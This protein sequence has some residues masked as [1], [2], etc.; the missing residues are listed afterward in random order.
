MGLLNIYNTIDH[1]HETLVA[2][3][4]LKDILPDVDFNHALVIKAGNRLNGEYIVSEDDVLYIRKVPGS[5]AV[6][7]VI[8]IVCAVVAVG[9]GVGSAIYAQKASKKAEEQME[10]AQRDAQNLSQ[11]IQQLPFIR[12]AKN[13]RALGE[14]VQFLMGS[15]YN[16]P[17]NLTDGFYSIGGNDGVDSYYSAAFSCGFNPQKITKILIGNEAICT[18][19]DGIDGVLSFDSS[20]I[21]FK[22]NENRVEVCQPGRPLSLIN[23]MQKVNATYAGAELKHDYGEAAVPVIV[24]AANNAMQIQVCI[25]FS[26]LRKYD[27][28]SGNWITNRAQ[29]SPYWS[30]NGGKTWHLFYFA[31]AET[32]TIK[33]GKETI[34]HDNVF[35]RNVN[36]NIR[37]V[38]TKTFTAEESYGKQISIKVVKETPKEK[39]N[40]QEDCA[41][42]WYQT[43]CYD[44]QKSTSSRLEMCLIEEA[45]LLNKTTRV[46]YRIIADS[47][48]QNLLDELHCVTEAE[49]RTW[50]GSAWSNTK[51]ATRNPASW[52]LEV[53]TSD[54]HKPSQMQDSELDLASFGALYEYCAENNFYCDG[55]I[56]RSEKK[57]DVIERILK[58]C[59]ASLIINNEGLYEVCI[60]K[61]EENPV[62]LL[63][64]ENIVSFSFSK[65]LAKK[66]DGSKVTFTNRDSWTVDTFYSMLNGG[67]YDYR[68]DTVDTL[69]IE[70]ATTYEHAY[71]I[72][73]RQLRQRQLQPREI[74][75][76]V[77][78]EGDYYPLYSTVLLQLPHLLQGL[79]SSVI[80]AIRF[81]ANLEITEIEI[82]DLVDFVQ[83]KRYGVIIQATND[84]GHK[85][86][87]GE[88]INATATSSTRILTF[89]APLAT[90]GQIIPERG[91]H[92]SFGLLD[93]NGRFSKITNVMKI[94]GIEPNGKDG[95]TLTLR[96]YSKEVYA[97]TP[98]GVPIPAYHS[99][100]TIPQQKEKTVSLDDLNELR[101]QMN[102]SIDSVLINPEDGTNPPDVTGL[103]ASASKDGITIK[104]DSVTSKGLVNSAKKYHIEL[105]K[106]N[107]DTWQVL[108]VS[109]NNQSF[110]SFVRTGDGADGY[111]EASLFND[112]LFRVKAE[113]IYGAI[114][115][116]W[117]VTDNIDVSDYGTWIPAIPTLIK[118][119]AEEGGI[120]FKWNTPAGAND[121]KLYGANTYEIN[122]YY[123]N[124]LR[125]T[126]NIDNLEAV[127]NFDRSVDGYPEKPSVIN[128][129]VTLDKYTFTIK[130]INESGNQRESLTSLINYENYKTWIPHNLTGQYAPRSNITKRAVTIMFPPQ[131]DV[132]GFLLYG[133]TV[134]RRLTDVTE[135]G[136]ESVRLFYTPDLIK[137]CYA[138]IDSYK[139]DT[140][141]PLFSPTTFK[142]N[143]PLLGQNMKSI[144]VD[145]YDVV[146]EGG[147]TS[148]DHIASSREY[149]VCDS[150]GKEAFEKLYGDYFDFD[151][152]T[153]TPQYASWILAG[154]TQTD[155]IERFAAVKKISTPIPEATEYIYKIFARN[156]YGN[157]I[158]ETV[159]VNITAD[160][161][162]VADLVDKAITV[163]KLDDQCV[164]TSKIAA[165]AITA[166]E[167]AAVN[168]LAKG[169]TAGTMTAEGIITENSGFWSSKAMRYDYTDPDNVRKTYTTKPG[170][171]FVGNN[172]A[173]ETAPT[174]ADEYLHFIPATSGH[175]SQFFL[176]I[177]NI[178]LKSLSTI[179]KGV[180]RVKNSLDDLDE[181]SFMSVNP[182]DKDE[183]GVRK[184]TINVNGKI[185]LNGTDL[186][187]IIYPVGSLYWTSKTPQQFDPNT[188][189]GGTWQQVKD[190]FILAAGDTYSNGTNGG[191]ATDSFTIKE[192]NL[193]IHTHAGGGSV[194]VY[195]S[196]TASF[197]GTTG[198]AGNHSHGLGTD[199]TTI[200]AG[201]TPNGFIAGQASFTGLG[202]NR[203]ESAGNHSHS[204]SGSCTVGVYSSGNMPA[205]GANSTPNTAITVKT[206][207]PYLVRYCWERIPDPD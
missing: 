102:Q 169:A 53:L 59:N 14:A 175:A 45:E 156:D 186:L 100:I 207:P 190:R 126:I 122:L 173:H 34:T 42:L 199:N 152:I 138:D 145:R 113:N 84:Y 29:V 92:L 130:V 78:H 179:V 133:L 147:V 6:I 43:F 187:D 99:N 116:N 63:N 37:F 188:K 94:Y 64:A 143:L 134:S 104:W 149:Y 90:D 87:S 54:V 135:E 204:F 76:D 52:L 125:A 120:I 165:G 191:S 3:G 47:S 128:A 185:S 144:Q 177:K 55:I 140:S 1:T 151:E 71:K 7:A 32:E 105:S 198:S 98:A 38:A 12:G 118:K 109:E 22:N 101:N 180:F 166:D 15:V 142:Q 79:R 148:P 33:Q 77:G 158:T 182:T 82:S 50:N 194:Y 48:T 141:V 192:V 183:A 20:S 70:Y 9:V 96:D 137:D 129:P 176:A 8:A 88:V 44:A 81:N 206:M 86:Y 60:D 167:I 80:K 115:E 28:D 111:P 61:E 93:E 193:P 30:N 110:Y 160:A 5:S 67:Y 16:T 196:G 178:L 195:G 58:L 157:G 46:A 41:L 123:D 95:F 17:Y 106:N 155:Y 139:D 25:Q 150:D 170:E 56:A 11:Q 103:T 124:S 68:N 112:W 35:K 31:G 21:Y 119:D 172:P 163:N 127:Y 73:Q 24:Q 132:Y 75:V 108:P 97:Y 114:S 181:D 85:M 62:A 74:R 146:T 83:N 91:N 184:K 162:S 117:T 136:G 89:A 69:A 49:A 189:F 72:A 10:K 159:S 205:T 121:K 203:T 153:E 19:S 13:R 161:N 168:I 36:H 202:S 57:K 27:S 39:S 26:S 23:C 40:T 197:S 174:D 65:S 164:T 131:E 66:V 154:G 171:F 18:R 4:R 200:N 2:N 51:S 107:G 201:W